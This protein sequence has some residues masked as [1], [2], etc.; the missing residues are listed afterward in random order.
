MIRHH[1]NLEIF[2]ADTFEY[3][4]FLMLIAVLQFTAIFLFQRW[5]VIIFQND[6]FYFNNSYLLLRLFL[7]II[8]YKSFYDIYKYHYDPYLD[9]CD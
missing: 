7:L 4:S 1:F 9:C 8:F 5:N 6:F 2:T 3:I